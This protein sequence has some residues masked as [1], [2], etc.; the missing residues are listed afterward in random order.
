MQK[1][2]RRLQAARALAKPHAVVQDHRPEGAVAAGS[3]HRYGERGAPAVDGDAQLLE[4]QALQRRWRDERA[5]APGEQGENRDY[6]QAHARIVGRG[7]LRA[8]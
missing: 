2:G 3:E 1:H 6:A 4:H 8:A 7:V 5:G